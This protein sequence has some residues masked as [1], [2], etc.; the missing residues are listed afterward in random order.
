MTTPLKMNAALRARLNFAQKMAINEELTCPL[1][2]FI[3]AD[4]TEIVAAIPAGE[5]RDNFLTSIVLRHFAGKV[6]AVEA[7]MISE[8]WMTQTDKVAGESEGEWAERAQRVRPRDSERRV[9]ALLVL[10]L[11]RGRDP[12]VAIQAMHR[13]GRGH[14][15]FPE[16]PEVLAGDSTDSVWLTVLDPLPP[17]P[18]D[19]RWRSLRRKLDAAVVELTLRDAEQ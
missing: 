13:D 10:Q 15:V 14:K 1:W 16:W 19:E 9:E 5:G 7:Y 12:V 2:N 8:V 6:G 3:T 17:F 11:R 4:R 18:D